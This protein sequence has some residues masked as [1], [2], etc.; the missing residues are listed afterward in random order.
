MNKQKGIIIGVLALVVTMMVGYAI[1][2]DTITINGTAT[3]KGEFQLTT[4]VVDLN[5]SWVKDYG[6]LNR[7]AVSSG[8]V[9]NPS[10]SVSGNVVTTSV[11]LG[12][13]GSFYNFAIKIKNTGTIPAKLSS[14]VDKTRNVPILDSSL[15]EGESYGNDTYIVHQDENNPRGNFMFAELGTD[16]GYYEG[17][18]YTSDITTGDRWFEE[19]NYTTEMLKAVLDPGEEVYYFIH[20]NWAST[21]TVPGD[22]LTLNWSL[23]FNYEQISK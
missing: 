4:S 13:P 7:N 14:I 23:E 18:D 8:I 17:D 9:N 16:S 20:Y 19:Q 15:G 21:S 2:S 10:I 22:P 12:M 11:E 1:F 6:F 5:E 3:A